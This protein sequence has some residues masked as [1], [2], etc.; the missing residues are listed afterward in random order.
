MHLKSILSPER[1]QWGAHGGSKK[2]TFQAI[3][4]FLAEHIPQFSEQEIYD[5]LL[6]RE[7]LGST[8]IGKGVAIP[9]S[10]IENCVKTTGGLFL[11]NEKVDFEAPD[12]EP[13]D[14]VFV[15]LVPTEANDAHL[16]V[17][18][19]LATLFNND[20]FTQALRSSQSSEELFN[21]ALQQA[22]KILS[23]PRSA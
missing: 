8:A 23:L 19:E 9:H 10:R 13:V 21:I 2:R 12:N 18:S 1:T 7:K 16:Q 6:N 20:Q 17:L 22:E 15:L 4:A 14:L 3:S 11:L 5:A